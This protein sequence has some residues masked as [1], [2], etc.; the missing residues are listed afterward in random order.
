MTRAINVVAGIVFNVD[1]SQV[2]L[3][4]RKPEQH[5]GDRWEFPG[6]KID[7]GESHQQALARELSEELDIQ[8]DDANHFHSL[9]FDYP[10]K[11]VH[12]HFYTVESFSGQPVGVEGQQVKWFPLKELSSL[13]FPDANMPVV[14]QLLSRP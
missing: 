4:L 11:S 10:E 7:D 8:I 3:S 9:T 1:H 12:L 14:K 5:Q 2:L 6:G 13:P